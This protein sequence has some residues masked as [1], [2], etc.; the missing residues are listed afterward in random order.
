MKQLIPAQENWLMADY[1]I[2]V[3]PSSKGTYVAVFLSSC[4]KHWSNRSAPFLNMPIRRKRGGK[5]TGETSRLIKQRRPCR[6]GSKIRCW[7]LPFVAAG[8]IDRIQLRSA[9][10]AGRF[11]EEHQHPS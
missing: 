3:P 1:K 11:A 5:R 2:I 4:A 8:Q 7:H 9:I 6:I 10:G